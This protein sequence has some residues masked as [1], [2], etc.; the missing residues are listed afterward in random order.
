[1]RP[2]RI[3]IVHSLAALLTLVPV[4][5]QNLD[6]GRELFSSRYRSLAGAGS[7]VTSGVAALDHNPAGLAGGGDNQLSV[8]VSGALYSYIL[9][10]DR[11]AQDLLRIFRWRKPDGDYPVL[12][13]TLK[14]NDRLVLGLGYGPQI[15]PYLFN[16]RR[17]ITWSP[18]FNQMT[19]GSLNGLLAALGWQWHRN[20]KTGIGLRYLSGLIRSEVHGEN[21]G[22]DETKWARLDTRL[23]GWDLRFG[24]QGQRGRFS[25]GA[26][27]ATPLML[28]ARTTTALSADSLYISL[29]PAYRRTTWNRPWNFTLGVAGRLGPALALLA[30][31]ETLNYSP[32]DLQ[33]NLFEYGGRPNWKDGYALRFAIDYSPR[34]GRP[35]R[36]GYARLPQI[37]ASVLTSGTPYQIAGNSDR[38]QNIRHLLTV[39][40]SRRYHDWELHYG[41]EYS[42]LYWRRDFPVSGYDVTEDYR[43]KRYQVHLQL[44][45]RI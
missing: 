8:T 21:H 27:A 19:D 33:L 14:F 31:I 13:A 4:L 20:W 3:K 34:T 30:D 32:G 18:L 24:L 22:A 41:L 12:A 11:T 2:F 40:S 36:L 5:A 29:L 25:W 35:L 6:L 38:D 15:S 45:R 9:F 39:G 17:A 43:E 26:T 7:A 42:W 16:R 37:Y 28:D 23:W 10:N 44:V 1:M